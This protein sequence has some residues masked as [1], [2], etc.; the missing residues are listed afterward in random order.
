MTATNQAYV[1][2][3]GMVQRQAAMVAFVM[4]FRMLGVLFLVMIPL[5]F[6]MKKTK[7]RARPGAEH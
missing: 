4:I 3:N 6:I 2:L 1:A 7:A 5:V